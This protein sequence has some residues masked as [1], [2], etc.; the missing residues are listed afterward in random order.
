MKK[1]NI[2]IC[3]SILIIGIVY[4]KVFSNNIL[5]TKTTY[6]YPY[7]EIIEIKKN[8]KVYKGKA[9]DE[10]SIN[11]ANKYDFTYRNRVSNKDLEEI[12]SIINQMK[13]EEEKKENFSESYGIAINVG[14][15]ELYGCHCFSQEAVDKLNLIIKKYE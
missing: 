13:M 11:G 15:N 4:I 3:L 12:K 10:L 5:L 7:I 8:G 1:K 2:I 6:N 9:I 14:K